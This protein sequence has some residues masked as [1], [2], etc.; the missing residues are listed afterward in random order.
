MFRP[1]AID[2][3][4]SRWLFGA[5]LVT[6]ALCVLALLLTQPHWLLFLLSPLV[7]AYL[8]YLLYA[9]VLLRK[10]DAV[11]RLEWQESDWSVQLRN[12]DRVDV[13]ILPATLV[14]PFLLLIDAREIS[15]QQRFRIM[16]LSDSALPE[17]LRRLRV[18]AQAAV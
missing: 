17:K 8:V 9:F 14:L 13:E 1:D 7:V 16:L 4:P 18:C 2:I 10:A 6:A 3:R 15:G 5:W 11:V 12:G